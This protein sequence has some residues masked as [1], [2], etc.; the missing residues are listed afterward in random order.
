MITIVSLKI[1]LLMKVFVYSQN[2]GK[3][4]LTK[5]TPW[6]CLFYLGQQ[7]INCKNL[8]N[9]IETVLLLLV[10]LWTILVNTNEFCLIQWLNE[11]DIY[12]TLIVFFLEQVYISW[13]QIRVESW[14]ELSFWHK[15]KFFYP[16]IYTA[17]NSWRKIAQKVRSIALSPYRCDLS[18]I[19]LFNLMWDGK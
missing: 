12:S 3:Q 16:Y 17:R 6:Q 18:H 4:L 1:V 2:I 13:P 9:Y 8:L 10:Q 7:L 5:V 14:K 11:H 19:M 15:L